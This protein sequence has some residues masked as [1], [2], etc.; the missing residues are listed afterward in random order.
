M[1][2]AADLRSRVSSLLDGAT[3]GDADAVDR[4]VPLVYDE[5]R[6]MAR[7]QLGRE[8]DATLQTTALVHEAYIKLAGDGRTTS[9]GRA[10]FFAA[11]ATAMRQVLVDRAR[12]RNAHKRGGGAQL[13]TLGSNDAAVDAYAVELVEIDDALARLAERSPRQARIVECRF[14]AGMSVAETAQALGVS[15]RTVEA[16]WA[17]ARAWLYHALGRKA[18][19]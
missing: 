1:H 18:A 9:R 11:A 2:S 10:Y 12:R 7:R 14:F 19:P 15:A 5:L 13:V 6:A 4:L 16:D 17:T 8:R 3:A